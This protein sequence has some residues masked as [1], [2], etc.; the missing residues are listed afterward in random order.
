MEKLTAPQVRA[1]MKGWRIEVFINYQGTLVKG[2]KIMIDKIM[3]A[4]PKGTLFQVEVIK[5]HPQARHPQ[6]T[7]LKFHGPSILETDVTSVE[8]LAESWVNGNLNEVADQLRSFRAGR[9]LRVYE[10]V[11]DPRLIGLVCRTT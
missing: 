8:D 1:A 5:P 7:T 9:A 4:S 10:L 6:L 2:T 11:R 3:K